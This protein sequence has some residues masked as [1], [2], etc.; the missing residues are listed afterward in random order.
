MENKVEN[1]IYFDV[2]KPVENQGKKWSIDQ[3]YYLS[4]L[5]KLQ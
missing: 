4:K 2:K 3:G 5:W 1:S